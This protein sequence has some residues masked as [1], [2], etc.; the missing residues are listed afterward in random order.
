MFGVVLCLGVEGGVVEEMV[1][2]G[3]WCGG[4]IGEVV[5]VD[6]EVG[7]GCGY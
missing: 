6:C 5:E 1:V 3:V 7:V 2:Y 4:E